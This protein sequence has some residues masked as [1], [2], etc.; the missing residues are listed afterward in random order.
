ME[1]EV[2]MNLHIP[3]FDEMDFYQFQWKFNRIQ[4]YKKDMMESKRPK[5]NVADGSNF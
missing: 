5:T 3:Y 2:G 1:F 4:Q